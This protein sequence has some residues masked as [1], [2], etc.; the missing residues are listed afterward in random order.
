VRHLL[1][2]CPECLRHAEGERQVDVFT[3][4][5]YEMA[6]VRSR[7]RTQRAEGELMQQRSAAW[8]RWRELRGK[9]PDRWA[10]RVRNDRRLHTWGFCEQLLEEGAKA[11]QRDL[12]AAEELAR[13]AVEVAE[14]LDEARHGA[15]RVA[16]LR[17]SSWCAV[18]RAR[19]LRWDLSGAR[20]A[21]ARAAERWSGGTGDPLG[22][23]ELLCLEAGLA[24]ESGHFER[25]LGAARR[26]AGLAR[27]ARDPYL[28]AMARA[29]AGEAESWIDP[30]R[31]VHR[32]RQALG[33]LERGRDPRLELEIRQALIWALAGDGRVSQAAMLLSASRDLYDRFA[34]PGDPRTRLRRRWLEGRIAL[35][36]GDLAQAETALGEVWPELLERKVHFAFGMVALDLAEVYVRQRRFESALPLLFGPR[37]LWDPPPEA[38]APRAG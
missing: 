35:S 14:W 17:A 22:E 9:G 24:G 31:A 19:R 25:A 27:Y 16:D 15:A 6:L 18:G 4:A 10:W 26:A 2:A 21:L 28:E 1:A 13:A 33:L 23:A 37:E 11:A 5:G 12:A 30:G 34:D 38:R 7:Q 29:A 20:E 8:E 3:G 32:L 36:R